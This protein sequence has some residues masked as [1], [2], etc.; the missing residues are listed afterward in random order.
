MKMVILNSGDIEASEELAKELLGSKNSETKRNKDKLVAQE[1]AYF[2]SFN[3]K[4]DTTTF[5]VEIKKAGKYAFF[6]EHMPLNL[7]PT[8]ISLRIFQA[9]VEPIAQVPDE[10]DHHHHHDHGGLDPHIWH[11]LITSSR[12]EMSF[13]KISI[14]KF[15]SLMRNKSFK[16][17]DSSR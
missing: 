9:N 3:E 6:T 11:D 5:T 7:K 2:L 12:W 15:P 1:K 8:N 10:G 17:E 13:L 16:R 4:K 14:R